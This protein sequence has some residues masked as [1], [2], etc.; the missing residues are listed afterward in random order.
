MHYSDGTPMRLGDREKLGAAYG[1]VVFI[2]DTGDF[3]ACYPE[4][5]WSYLQRGL[6]VEFDR[7][8]LIQYS[9]TETDLEF[10]SRAPAEQPS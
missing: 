2:I 7:F 5:A 3:S 4:S 1:V 6:M 10:V 9:T 8:G